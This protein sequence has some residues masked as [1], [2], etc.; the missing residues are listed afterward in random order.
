MEQAVKR[1]DHAAVVDPL[2]AVE[3]ATA[4]LA[5]AAKEGGR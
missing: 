1:R 3:N 5:R 4:P 2:R